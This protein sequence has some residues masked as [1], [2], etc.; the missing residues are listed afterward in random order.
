[1]ATNSSSSLEL[2]DLLSEDRF[3]WL[4]GNDDNTGSQLP[5]ASVVLMAVVAYGR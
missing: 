3:A 5:V 2:A 1:M 4:S